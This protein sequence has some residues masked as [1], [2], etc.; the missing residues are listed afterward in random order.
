[1]YSTVSAIQTSYKMSILNFQV[2]S[3]PALTGGLLCTSLIRSKRW[4]PFFF[5]DTEYFRYTALLEIVRHLRSF[6]L[7]SV[8]LVF[9]RVRLPALTWST[10]VSMLRANV[11][12]AILLAEPMENEDGEQE[13]DVAELRLKAETLKQ[14]LKECRA[15][16]NKLQKQLSQSERLQ[17]ST[18]SYNEDLRK[19]VSGSLSN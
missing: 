6:S 19:Q 17:R 12:M 5:D 2:G 13:S 4:E 15:E 1:M 10:F 14:E 3:C 11:N 16:L 8:I 7:F 18:E 9:V